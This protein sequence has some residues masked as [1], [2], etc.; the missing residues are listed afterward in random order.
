MQKQASV[1]DL[2]GSVSWTD[3]SDISNKRTSEKPYKS[4]PRV[5]SI[6]GRAPVTLDGTTSWERASNK[7]TLSLFVGMMVEN[8][9]LAHMLRAYPASAFESLLTTDPL[10]R[11]V[12]STIVI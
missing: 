3:P 10:V 7:D 1:F 11:G 6:P 5:I 9:R 2:P 8:G 4:E 12:Y